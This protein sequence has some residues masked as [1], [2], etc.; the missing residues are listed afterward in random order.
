MAHMSSV[1]AAKPALG[2]MRAAVITRSQRVEICEATAP[3]PSAHEVRERIEG[4]GVSESN[5]AVW[6]GRN[7]FNYRRDAGGPGCEAWGSGGAVGRGGKNLSPGDRGP[8]RSYH[9]FAG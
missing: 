2:K 6:E 4:C 1:S 7:W 8:M 3:E 5:M 9:A